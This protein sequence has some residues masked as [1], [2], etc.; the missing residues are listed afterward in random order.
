MRKPRTIQQLVERQNQILG[1]KYIIAEDNPFDQNQN[2]QPESQPTPEPKVQGQEVSFD[3]TTPDG[4]LGDT[5]EVDVTDLI[6]GQEDVS[7]KVDSFNQQITSLNKILSNLESK[8]NQMDELVGKI[9]SIE[10][11]LKEMNPTQEEK[12]E[13]V[14]LNTYPYNITL[15]DF[16]KDRLDKVSPLTLNKKSDDNQEN[17]KKEEVVFELT[18]DVINDYNSNDIEKSFF[19]ESHQLKKKDFFNQFKKRR[20]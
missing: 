18:D 3:G 16:W 20:F 11:E 14:S 5:K 4:Q 1:Y 12:L 9:N 10:T 17:E 7:Q 2:S 8:I 6:K 19:P 13:M 15:K